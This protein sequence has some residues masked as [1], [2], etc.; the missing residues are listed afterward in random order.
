MKK[1]LL[2][3]L[4][5]LAGCTRGLTPALVALDGECWAVHK[6]V[7]AN[8][9]GEVTDAPALYRAVEGALDG[10]AFLT[11]VMDQYAKTH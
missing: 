2:L 9:F 11:S 4:V 7:I 6:V 1:V 5:L 8:T 10:C 3:S